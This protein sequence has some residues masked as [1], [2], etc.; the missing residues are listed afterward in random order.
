MFSHFFVDRPKFA[1]VISIVISIAGGLS[2]LALPVAEYPQI[3]PPT[4]SV[5]TTYPGANAE[6]VEETVTA[7]LEDV[8]N[9]VENM[10]YIS[11]KSDNDGRANITVT[12]AVGTDADIAS[13]QV[14]NRVAQAMP[15]LPDEV[16]RQGVVT[17]KQS[18]D[19]LLIMNLYSP[20]ESYDALF[21]NNYARINVL[22]NLARV[23]GVAKAEI[24]GLM[25]YGMR[26]WLRPDRMASL[27]VTVSEIASAIQ[28]QNVQVAAGQVGAP[29][30]P[31]DQ[32][33]QYTV[34]TKGRLAEVE[35]FSNIILRMNPDGSSL[36]V[37]DVARVELGSQSYSAEGRLNGKPSVILAIYQ[38]P[39]A[40]AL[41]VAD[42]VRAQLENLK[43]RFPD[44]MEHAF[45]YDTTRF[46]EASIN[47]V[48]VTLFQAVGLVILVVFIFLGNWRSTLVPGIAIPVSLIGTFAAL[49]AMGF[50]LN[51]IVL[52]ALILAIG[53]VVDDAIVVVENVQRLMKEESLSPRDATRKAMSQVGGAIIATT[54]VLFA[55]F[56]PVAFMPGITGELYRQFA[57]TIAF[58]VA[59]SSIN[60]LTLSPALCAT[61]L[62]PDAKPL[63]P[64]A[65]F[66]RW[67]AGVTD[68]YDAAVR[69]LVK[70][71]VLALL[72]FGGLL[73]ITVQLFRTLPTGFLPVEDKGY[74]MV[75]VQLPDAASLNRTSL[76]V[77][78]LEQRVL[79]MPGV[80]DVLS[81]PGFSMLNG[82]ISP[83][84]AM[85]IVILAPW[86]EREAPDLKLDALMSR[87]QTAFFANRSANAFVFVPPP[88]P[89]LGST[90]GFSFELQDLAGGNA[91]D[92][93][94]A[95]RALVFEANQHPVLDG[96]FSTFRSDVPRIYLDV[97]REKAK[98]LGV[99]MNEIFLTLQAQLGSLYIN[100]FNLF[101]RTWRVM[102]QAEQ[103]FRAKPE[104]IARLFVRNENGEMVPLSTLVTTEAD[105]GPPI[106]GRY[107]LYKSASVSGNPSSGHSSGEALLAMESVAD[108]VL[109]ANYGYSWTALSQQ[110]REAG[111][112][113]IIIFALAII[114]VYLFLVAQYESWTISFAVM[115][116]VP[117]AVFG[118]LASVGLAGM[119]V[120]IYTQIGLVMLIG[121]AAKNAILIVEFA[122]SLR[123]AGNSIFDSA[124]DAARLRFRAVM[125]TAISFILGVFPLV[126]ASGAGAGSRVSLGTAVFGGMIAATVVGTPLI[127]VF[128]YAIQSV[129]EKIKGGP[130]VAK[131]GGDEI[132]STD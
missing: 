91:G 13:V 93:A 48:V 84:A 127:P 92:L 108:R 51:T 110:E 115:L 7:P 15:K 102:A 107:N 120:N 47:E 42:G 82:A 130:V 11:S 97:D 65:A 68:R 89:G 132:P 87:A 36:R 49:A 86:E 17:Q 30:A 64:L 26:I 57:V 77:A 33:F 113:T 131:T 122:K 10:I 109:P 129:R 121:L 67:F 94:A 124:V 71:V 4:V 125:M 58:A 50:S 25:D 75:D 70:R 118:A 31:P 100:D 119:D 44:D 41:A 123:E 76:V 98:T 43:S 112:Q 95:L 83:N 29:P 14:Q 21:L 61:L 69:L 37:G 105:T 126:V 3:T 103:E 88:I 32:Q 116:A 35:E 81:V 54:L 8:I 104:D 60:A 20:G 27:G 28:E 40:N 106:V 78:D 9:G 56:V 5:S 96:V 19:M 22:D 53:I 1:F 117:V 128:Y 23:P 101:G 72:V 6:V 80:T 62:K 73:L 90:S 63:A 111:A 52:F 39:D 12:F 66:D 45:L 114:F 55:V 24:L 18:T 38:L 59:I 16:K 79:E 99:P 34:V 46:I 85:M 74:F 2:I